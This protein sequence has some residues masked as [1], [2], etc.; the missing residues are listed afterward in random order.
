MALGLEPRA[1]WHLG[2]FRCPESQ[3]QGELDPWNGLFTEC[4]LSPLPQRS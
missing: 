2:L 3:I 4:F 1:V